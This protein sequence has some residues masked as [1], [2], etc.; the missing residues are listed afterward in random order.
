[1]PGQ[2]RSALSAPCDNTTCLQRFSP[3][4]GRMQGKDFHKDA[5]HLAEQLIPQHRAV[6]DAKSL[7]GRQHGQATCRDFRA[8]V[9]H[10]LPHR[11]VAGLRAAMPWAA[12]H[13]A[14]RPCS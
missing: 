14:W 10:S 11:Q 1:M 5:A 6:L 3:S 2:V 13:A 4:L 12:S 8:S 9:L 7:E